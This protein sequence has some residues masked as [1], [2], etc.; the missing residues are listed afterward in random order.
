MEKQR[1][2][3]EELPPVEEEEQSLMDACAS[4]DDLPR[5]ADDGRQDVVEFMHEDQT[6]HPSRNAQVRHGGDRLN[7]SSDEAIGTESEMCQSSQAKRQM[8]GPCMGPAH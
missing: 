5:T 7:D 6:T 3:V 4:S 8:G 2:E 1:V